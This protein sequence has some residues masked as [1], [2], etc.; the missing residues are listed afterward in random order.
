MSITSHSNIS[1]GLVDS[2]I[3]EWEGWWGLEGW[4]G[5]VVALR[6]ALGWRGLT[7][8][9][10]GLTITRLGRHFLDF[11]GFFICADHV[12]KSVVKG[13][14][15]EKII[16]ADKKKKRNLKKLFIPEET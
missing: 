1:V 7:G 11:N 16:Y 13:Y 6:D 4:I 14:P 3:Y 5:G 12:L 9:H 8:F 2:N 15:Q 10:H